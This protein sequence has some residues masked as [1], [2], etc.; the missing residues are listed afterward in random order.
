MV[1][2][3]SQSNSRQNLLMVL[4]VVAV[5]FGMM[6]GYRALT[7]QA[8]NELGVESR[9]R[10]TL[11][12]SNL[13]GVLAK[14]EHLP[15][16]I[17]HNPYVL[18]ALQ[19]S[20]QSQLDATNQYLESV[21]ESSGAS[22]VYLLNKS[23][24][25]IAA[26]NWNLDR[27]F[28]GR[29]YS[30]R[31]YYKIAISG[32][33]GRYFALGIQSQ[34]RGYYFSYP[35]FNEKQLMGVIVVKI[36]LADIEAAWSDRGN[37][38]IVTDDNG[39]VFLSTQADWT[40]KSIRKIEPEKLKQI[41]QSRQYRNQPI[42]PLDFTE[43]ENLGDAG[44]R[45]RLRY[46][47]GSK[48]IDY[49]L[50]KQSMPDAGWTAHILSKTK[51]VR[52][53]VVQRAS[54][55]ALGTLIV[56]LLVILYLVNRQRRLALQ[57]STE[58]L[59]QR[60]QRR[61]QEL[62]NEVEERRKAEQTLRDTQAELIQAAKLAGLGQMSAGISHEL[63][64]PLTAIR[65]YSENAQRLLDRKQVEAA[66]DNLHEIIELTGRMASIISQL[67]G[68]SRKSSGERSRVSI[69]QSVDQALS[70]FEREIESS[71]VEV[72][73]QIDPDL[74]VMT[75]PL[76]LNQVLVNLF[77]NAIQAMAAVETRT[78]EI[79]SHKQ[80]SDIVI[81]ISDSGPG[82]AP[83]VIENIFDPFF[84]TKEVGLGLGLGL[85]ISYR[86]ME[87]LGGRI[88]VANS[89]TGGARFEL[90]LADE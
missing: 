24:L 60:V 65:N 22:D 89:A 11:F 83:H 74:S 84:T 3:P 33:A 64:Q 31:P 52:G 71:Q 40:Y 42:L 41:R 82:V 79:D 32:E 39:I 62:Q 35:V 61:T 16:L 76:L 28:I 6:W 9:N 48:T 36:N 53:T 23:G 14:Y 5:G 38:F 51:T 57:G 26:S 75:D 25:T 44:S 13:D 85:S 56:L 77:S 81:S 18:N 12:V 10:L 34:Q 73:A 70:M 67:R 4:L 21:A 63:N 47:P 45:F 49:L 68:F 29:N 87:S 58:L 50:L 15:K 66:T 78:I 54:L 37:D 2:H 1:T 43:T 80:N 27:S 8:L 88:E 69:E 46:E 90:H 20:H 19:Q 72:K 55:A 7:Y 86:I 30:F 59:E 17:S